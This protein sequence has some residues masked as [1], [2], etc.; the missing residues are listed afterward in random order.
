MCVHSSLLLIKV[1]CAVNLWYMLLVVW[2]S[3]FKNE[4]LV[5]LSESKIIKTRIL[6][7]WSM[8]GACLWCNCLSDWNHISSECT[9]A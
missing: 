1:T 3:I 5:M 9:P 4:L 2:T 6:D 8:C 7:Q